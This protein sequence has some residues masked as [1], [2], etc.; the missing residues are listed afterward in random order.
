L[1]INANTIVLERFLSKAGTVLLY[2]QVYHCRR[3]VSESI[4]QTDVVF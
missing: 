1:K 4:Q 3:V 2:T